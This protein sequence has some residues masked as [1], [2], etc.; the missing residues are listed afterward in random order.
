M[1]IRS[2]ESYM[3]HCSSYV[4][5]MQ[6]KKYKNCTCALFERPQDSESCACVL[7]ES[8][9]D[10]ENESE[11]C[12][13]VLFSLKDSESCVCV[14]QTACTIFSLFLIIYRIVF[15]GYREYYG[16]DGV[17][18]AT[19]SES[20]MYVCAVHAHANLFK[21]ASRHRSPFLVTWQ[22]PTVP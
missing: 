18:I 20:C 14:L 11:S 2:T 19:S 10:S 4:H 3:T 12:V 16:W 1:F 7:F 8:L 21:T 15:R 17:Y 6:I 9:K 22:S 13:S 5:D